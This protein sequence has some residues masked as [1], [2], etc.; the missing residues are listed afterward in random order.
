MKRI[1]TSFMVAALASASIAPS[2]AYTFTVTPLCDPFAT[3]DFCNPGVT[4]TV[5]D[6][7]TSVLQPLAPETLSPPPGAPGS[8]YSLFL[9]QTTPNSV[10]PPDRAGTYN[11]TTQY[12]FDISVD[13]GPV[14]TFRVDGTVTGQVSLNSA[15]VPGSDAFFQST[16]VTDLTTGA[17][18]AAFALA[19][20]ARESL[21][22]SG[23]DFGN[24]VIGNVWVDF[25]QR[26]T[27]PLGNPASI[28]GFFGAT[29][30]PEPGAVA[31]LIGSGLGGGLLVIRRRRRA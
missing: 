4:T 23:I 25:R 27:P 13:G 12:F 10:P 3:G 2:L 21:V 30:V 31:M 17:S 16:L 14:H 11:S 6:S 20:D 1:L 26:I 18:S 7:F 5:G 8:G 15:F 9:I 28:G 19:P 29:V 24:G 22:L